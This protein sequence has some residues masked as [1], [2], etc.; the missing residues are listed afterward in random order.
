MNGKVYRC[1]VRPAILYGSEAW[2]LIEN[3][4]AILRKNERIIVR[5]TCGQKVDDRKT[6]EE[7]IG[8]LGLRESIVRLATANGVRWYGHVLRRDDDSVLRVALDLEVSSK[9]K[10]G[11]PKK[12]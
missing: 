1:C 10:R 7:Q 2:C 3:E 11:R 6:N 5:A 12:T 8:M 9:R 4:K